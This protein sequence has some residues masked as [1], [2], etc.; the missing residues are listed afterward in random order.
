VLT[1]V[2]GGYVT[3]NAAR[4]LYGVV[5]SGDGR[6]LDVPATTALREKVKAAGNAAPKPSEAAA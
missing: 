4:E 5:L 2:I 6:R 3:A 1:D